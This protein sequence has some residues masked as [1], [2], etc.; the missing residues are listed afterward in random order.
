VKRRPRLYF[1]FRSPYSWM[2]VQRLRREIPNLFDVAE[3]Y[4]YWDPDAETESALRQ[5]GARLPYQAMSKA[6]HL[7][8]LGDTKRLAGRLGLTMA[9]PVDVDPWWEVPHL[10]WLAARRL[11]AAQQCYDALVAARWQRGED[12]CERAVLRRVTAAAGLPADLLDAAVDDP[13]VRA[14]GVR[15]LVDAY[16]D[17]IF[18]VPYL[19]VGRQRFW[20]FDRVEM[21]LEAYRDAAGAEADPMRGVPVAAVPAGGYDRDTA[22]GCG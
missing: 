1:S 21:F 12:I 3:W 4:P 16:E 9:W 17:D 20:G 19:R 11:G 6:K 18:G 10:A 15:C 5:V 13:R 2:A 22:G 7:Y 8:V 14:D